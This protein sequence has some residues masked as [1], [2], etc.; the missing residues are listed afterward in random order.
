M[1]I[2][3]LATKF[4]FPPPR[5]ELVPRPRLL[6]SLEAGL[7]HA[8]GFSRKLTLVSAPAGYG[9]TT[10]IAE[11]LDKNRPG[12]STQAGVRPP[13]SV[14]PPTRVAWLS[15]EESDNDPRRFLAYLIAALRTA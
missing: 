7:Y 5:A 13:A 1:S 6:E 8:N 2:P 12:V 4:Y 9:K 10:L 3:L 14:R 11:W 15:L